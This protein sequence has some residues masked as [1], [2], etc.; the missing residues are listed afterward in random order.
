MALL[1]SPAAWAEEDVTVTLRELLAQY[2]LPPAAQRHDRINLR[3]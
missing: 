1:V 3:D 2:L